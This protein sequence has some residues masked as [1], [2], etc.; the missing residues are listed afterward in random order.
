LILIGQY[1]CSLFT[2]KHGY[3][4]FTQ[5]FYSSSLRNTADL[6]CTRWNAV[7]IYFIFFVAESRLLVILLHKSYT[8]IINLFKVALIICLFF[9]TFVIL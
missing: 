1:S 2:I 5:R 9:L 6:P 7:A 3:D 8:L 4:R